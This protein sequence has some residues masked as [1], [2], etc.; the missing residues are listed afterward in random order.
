[1]KKIGKKKLFL[2]EL[3][4]VLVLFFLWQTHSSSEREKTVMPENSIE[5]H[6]IDVGQG[7]SI[8]VRTES[9]NLLIDA[10]PG[11][12][13]EKLADYL[14]GLGIESFEYCI[15]THPHEDHIGGADMIMRN[16]EVKN[17]I[18]SGA[19]TDTKTFSNL[20]YA[21]EESEANVIEASP[22]RTYKIGELEILIMGPCVVGKSRDLNNSSVI[23]RLT[24]GDV[25]ML[26]TGDAESVEE[27]DVLKEYSAYDLD[28]D[29]LKL[30]H[31]GSSTSSSEAFINA[32][33]P[34]FAAI[35]CG[36]DNSY[37]HP[38]RETLSML[39][40]NGIEYERTDKHGDI[41]YQC[42]GKN[43]EIKN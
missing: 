13:E 8:L 34:A 17:V 39:E 4:V 15:F 35:S 23:A 37:G 6:I 9:G 33:T 3:A 38:H 10:G 14:D 40:G 42:D 2:I 29:F 5:L 32:V 43:F 28:C 21:L 12:S 18:M 1:M 36:V 25:R 19:V 7:D 24:Y 41:V 26:F 22:D 11:D 31:H 30:G 27:S 20:L 16:Y